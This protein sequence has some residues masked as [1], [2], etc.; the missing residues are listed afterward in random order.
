MI[1]ILFYIINTYD[2]TYLS[3]FQPKWRAAVSF[4]LDVSISIKKTFNDFFN[5]RAVKGQFQNSDISG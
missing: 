3:Y 1:C 5:N 2:V 4:H